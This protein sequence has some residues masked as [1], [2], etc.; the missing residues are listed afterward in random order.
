MQNRFHF[1]WYRVKQFFKSRSVL[2]NLILVNIA[3]FVLMLAANLLV[4][5]SSYLMGHPFMLQ[6]YFDEYLA[7]HSNLHHLITHPWTMVTDLFVHSGFLHIFF[8]MLML[9]IVGKYFLMYKSEKQLLATYLLGGIAGN[10][11]YLA[12]YH[13]FPVFAPVADI[14]CC[15]GASGAVMAILFAVTIYRPDHPVPLFFL[16]TIALKWIALTFVILD[17]FGLVGSNAGGHFAHLGGAM[18][19]ACIALFFINKEKK[20][21]KKKREKRFYYANSQTSSRPVSDEDFNA[22]KRADEK[23]VDEILDKI[24]KAGYGALTSEEKEFLYHYRRN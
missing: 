13:V 22:Q 23:R 18:Y 12:A 21:Q 16:G 24:S 3:V 4:Y 7:L 1:F 15:V 14:S 6:P 17:L 8:N 20:P 11:V 2:S 10:I 19:G 5:V 9:Y